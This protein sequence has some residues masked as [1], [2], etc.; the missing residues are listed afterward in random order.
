MFTRQLIVNGTCRQ[1]EAVRTFG[2]SAISMKRGNSQSKYDPSG[3]ICAKE[4]LPTRRTP[5]SQRTDR[6]FQ[7]CLISF[8]LFCIKV[9][10]KVIFQTAIL[11]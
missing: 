4:V 6:R 1:A 3:N 2:V 7:A 10:P 5:V 11:L 8:K 9:E